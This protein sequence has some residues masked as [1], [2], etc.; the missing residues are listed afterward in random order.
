MC[1]CV[2]MCGTQDSLS[3][4]ESEREREMYNVYVFEEVTWPNTE[5]KRPDTFEC[6]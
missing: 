1:V 3:L 6:F 5:E 4:G 2:C